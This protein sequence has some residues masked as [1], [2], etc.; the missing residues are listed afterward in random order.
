M[1]YAARLLGLHAAARSGAREFMVLVKG[2]LLRPGMAEVLDA[3]IATE[4]AVV[5]AKVRRVQRGGLA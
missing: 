1:P 4:N 5:F 3:F 2:L